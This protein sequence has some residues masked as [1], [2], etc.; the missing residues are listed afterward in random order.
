MQI[1]LISTSDPYP[2]PSDIDCQKVG[3]NVVAFNWT[4]VVHQCP[5]FR[6]IITATGCGDCPN[7][8]TSTTVTCTNL[9]ESDYSVCTFAVQTEACG[10]ILGEKGN[11]VSISKND[12]V[13][14]I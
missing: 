12:I 4:E 1:T 6:Y 10:S 5:Y 11:S 14:I 13:C 7:T 9:S 8:T 2:P 3:S